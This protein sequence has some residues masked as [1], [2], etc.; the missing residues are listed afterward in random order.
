MLV[1][2]ARPGQL[3]LQELQGQLVQPEALVLLVQPGQRGPQA[4]LDQLG[5]QV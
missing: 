3:V 2:P 1:P 5:L 4:Q